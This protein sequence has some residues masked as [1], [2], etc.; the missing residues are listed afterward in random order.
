VDYWANS[1]EATVRADVAREV[2]DLA[3]SFHPHQASELEINLNRRLATASRTFQ[4]G[5]GRLTVTTEVRV[6]LDEEVREQLRP[7][8]LEQLR[9]E[10]EHDLKMRRAQMVETLTQQWADVIGRL[11]PTPFGTPAAKLS[12]ATLAM[13]LDE[14]VNKEQTSVEELARRLYDVIRQSHRVGQPLDQREAD[15]FIALL[16]DALGVKAEGTGESSNGSRP[17]E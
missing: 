3:R 14:L 11:R 16:N 15:E 10:T 12:D 8:L 5:G 2:A 13:I 17:K 4:R 1:L 9:M 7:S 6:R